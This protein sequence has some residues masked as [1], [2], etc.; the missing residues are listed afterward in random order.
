MTTRTAKRSRPAASGSTSTI[1]YRLLASPEGQ[2]YLACEGE[3]LVE[4][5]WLDLRPRV[6]ST[7]QR[8]DRLAPDLAKAIE[9]A[10]A[11]HAVD[12][13]P[14]TV[15]AAT[16]F[17]AACRRAAQ[18]IP[19]GSTIS[20]GEL[21]RRA[22]NP[23]AARAAGQ[24]MRRNPTPIVVPCHRVI[25]SDGGLGGF[26]GAMGDPCPALAVKTRLLERERTRA[27]RR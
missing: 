19:A 22:G 27:A 25:A 24:A 11:G 23:R 8:D 9:R 4:C 3:R 10:L 15:P 17:T 2:F 26:A 7:W 13:S 12:F 5:G 14:W 18:R 1:R 20:Y 21:A 6:P 16:P